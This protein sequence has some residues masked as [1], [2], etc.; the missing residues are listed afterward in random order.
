MVWNLAIFANNKYAVCAAELSKI[1]A[2]AIVIQAQH[3]G[4]C[5][6]LR[7]KPKV[8]TPRSLSEQSELNLVL[9]HQGCPARHGPLIASLAKIYIEGQ[10]L[11]TK[12]GRECNLHHLS[13]A[14]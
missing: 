2:T 13:L 4:T 10:I 7:P 1:I 12:F 6:H 11:K 3:I 14:I 5:P 8:D 9:G